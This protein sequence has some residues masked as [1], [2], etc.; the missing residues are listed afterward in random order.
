[1]SSS[2]IVK[3]YSKLS[4]FISNVYPESF[5]GEYVDGAHFKEW[6]DMF[7][8]S[9]LTCILAPRKHGKST[10]SYGYL[11]WKIMQN[12]DKD[13]E[14]LYISYK[15]DLA[16]Y[17]VKNMKHYLLKNPYFKDLKHISTAE[18]IVKSTWDGIHHITIEPAGIL[19]FKRGR[20]RR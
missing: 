17:H 16:R 6:A 13:L 15:E 19:S 1:M 2:T 12:V 4:Y 9:P 3:A 18:G 11:L 14:I 10:I 20:H 7:Q 8:D 5:E